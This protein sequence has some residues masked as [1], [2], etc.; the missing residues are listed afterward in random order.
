MRS[1]KDILK[2]AVKPVGTEVKRVPKCPQGYRY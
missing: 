1:Y 2:E